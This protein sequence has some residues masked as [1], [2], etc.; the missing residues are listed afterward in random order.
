VIC[1]RADDEKMTCEWVEQQLSAYHDGMLDAAAAG[2]VR[3]H[4]ASCAHCAGILTDYARFDQLLAQAPRYAPAPELRERIFTSPAFREIISGATGAPAR[5]A[6]PTTQTPTRPHAGPRLGHQAARVWLPVLALLVI[7]SGFTVAINTILASRATGPLYAA[8]PAALPAGGR[9]VYQ[10]N[11]SLFSNGAKLVCEARTRVTL[12]QVSPDGAWIAYV[13]ATTNTLRL[14]RA[15]ATDDHQIALPLAR[16]GS[17]V[18]LVW[19]PNSQILAII[20]QANAGGVNTYMILGTHPQASAAQTIDSFSAANLESGPV[21]SADSQSLAVAFDSGQPLPT[22]YLIR[23]IAHISLTSGAPTASAGNVI[24]GGPEAYL[25]WTTGANTALAYALGSQN[26]VQ[27]IGIINP[28]RPRQKW[29]LIN[30]TA[31]AFAPAT[32]QWAVAASDGSI[33]QIDAASGQ[34]TPLARIG[35][36]KSLAWS[37]DGGTLAAVS[38]GT[39]WLITATGATKAGHCDAGSPLA[40]SPDSALIAFLSRGMAQI[41]GVATGAAH[42]AASAGSVTGLAWS[43]DGYTLALWGS[44]GIT[45]DTPAGATIASFA[46]TPTGAPQWSVAA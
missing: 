14:V 34:Q 39:L 25:S 12:W 41:A 17:V 29:A 7:I 15:N 27:Q 1:R 45:L 30:A 6:A 37:P 16:D 20:T 10:A 24:G 38:N 33:S 28:N 36:V 42:P 44:R 19:S 11:G 46:A 9:L 23:I 13:D 43:P 31:V 40:W 3:E 35:P 2:Q 8:C 5:P 22:K 26:Q 18:G 21:W 32:G 4:L